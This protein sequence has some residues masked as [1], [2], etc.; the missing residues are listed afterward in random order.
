MDGMQQQEYKPIMP[1]PLEKTF[2]LYWKS[3]SGQNL[4][5]EF[6]FHPTRR[7]RFDFAHIETKTAIEI[8]GGIW[9]GGRHNRGAGFSA[10]CDKYNEAI[11]CGWTV[12][13]LTCPQI[14]IAQL[15]KIDAWIDRKTGELSQ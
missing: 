15:M 11:L 10:D 6:R 14:T 4:E 2:S 9:S 3:I 8:E 13:R 7:W 5:R 1:S 12:F